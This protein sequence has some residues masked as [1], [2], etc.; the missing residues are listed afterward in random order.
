MK[1]AFLGLLIILCFA[2]ISCPNGD[3]PVEH[4]VTFDPA[5]GTAIFTV[6][7][8]D[9]KK[10]TK[11]A[12]PTKG[13]YAFDAWFL[14]NNEF[15]FET[16]ITSD[17]ELTAKWENTNQQYEITFLNNEGI[18]IGEKVIVNENR[19]WENVTTPNVESYEVGTT[20]YNFS[21]W[22]L[23]EGGTAIAN[24]YPI[25]NHLTVH[26]VYSTQQLYTPQFWWGNYIPVEGTHQAT[27][28]LS[29][30]VFN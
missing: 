8:E 11:P 26:A 9:G 30:G 2:V 6:K 10:V 3:D 4:T 5:N 29:A 14:G 18:Q 22:S 24:N 28:N 23:T 21:H 27:P 7:V 19:R 16:P 25:N 13:G 17:I 15:D 20:R 12:D 1:K